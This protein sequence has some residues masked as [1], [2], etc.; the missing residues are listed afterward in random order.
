MFSSPAIVGLNAVQHPSQL[1]VIQK[2]SI[3]RSQRVA[4]PVPY[5]ESETSPGI[6]WSDSGDCSR[7]SCRMDTTNS[8]A[9]SF[10]RRTMTGSRDGRKS[11]P[12]QYS[13]VLVPS[14]RENTI[15]RSH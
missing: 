4:P 1:K 14:T 5:L 10:D 13:V 15:L 2:L 9:A 3:N 7:V 6:N 12:E 11:L 8:K